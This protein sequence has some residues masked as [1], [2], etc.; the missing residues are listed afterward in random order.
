[1]MKAFKDIFEGLKNKEHKALYDQKNKERAN[2]LRRERNKTVEGKKLKAEQGRRWRKKHWPIIL[3][4]KNKYSKKKRAEDPNYKL[5]AYC[6]FRIWSALKGLQK[7]KRTMKLLG[8]TIDELWTYLESK[9]TEGMTKENHGKWHVDHIIP[10]A[11]FDLSD[12]EQ[13]E[14]CFHYTN[15][16]PLWAIDNM[17]KHT[18]FILGDITSLKM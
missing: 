18:K 7:S 14:K 16:Q 15:L 3:A 2:F 1:M 4:K 6:R 10:C 8:C 5:K 12:P 11:S 13:Q 17:K 9:F